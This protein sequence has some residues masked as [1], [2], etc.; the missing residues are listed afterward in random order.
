MY[1]PGKGTGSFEAT[2]SD[3]IECMAVQWRGPEP[4][5]G[6]RLGSDLIF[7]VTT[8]EGSRK[9]LQVL[10]PESKLLSASEHG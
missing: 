3:R 4:P 9:Q 6:I 7:A 10:V 5:S 1:R 2:F 8:S